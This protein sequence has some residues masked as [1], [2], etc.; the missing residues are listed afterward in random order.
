MTHNAPFDGVGDVTGHSYPVVVPSDTLD[1]PLGPVVTRRKVFVLWYEV[2][3]QSFEILSIDFFGLLVRGS[4]EQRH[5]LVIEDAAS[6][7][8]ELFAHKEASST[9]F[10]R[11]MCL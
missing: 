11:L 4:E 5:I 8:L 1:R 7:W 2:M 10:K 6:H 3:R 9:N